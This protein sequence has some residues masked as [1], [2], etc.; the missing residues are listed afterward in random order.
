MYTLKLKKI[1]PNKN[2]QL[3]N[4]QLFLLMHSGKKEKCKYEIYIGLFKSID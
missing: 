1:S 2:F 3:Q 4:I